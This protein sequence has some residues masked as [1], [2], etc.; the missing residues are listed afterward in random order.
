MIKVE[1][2]F[3][4]PKSLSKKCKYDE[5]D[6]VKQL[7]H[8]FYEK[9]YIC[10][11]KPVQDPQIEH[12]LP[13]KNG[14]Y[15]DR[16]YDWNNLFFSCTHCNNIKNQSKYDE[17]LLDCCQKDPEKFIDF[18]V[19]GKCVCVRAKDCGDSEAV[20]T[21]TLVDEVF[22]KKNTGMR[23][24]KCQVRIDELLKEMNVL[25]DILEK[26]NDQGCTYRIKQTLK[27]LLDRKSSFAEFKRYYIKTHYDIYPN[28]IKFIN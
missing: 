25:F 17:G 1:R 27:G 3:P 7:K 10:G 2:T 12:F 23:V 4:A 28:I 6:V 11:I 21:A 19:D 16:K 15:I 26:Y 13:H 20:L 5:E 22:N 18:I 9:C 24:Y 14:R 8:D